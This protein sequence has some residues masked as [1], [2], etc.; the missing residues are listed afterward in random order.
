VGCALG[1][2]GRAFLLGAL[3]GAALAVA[4]PGEVRTDLSIGL[5]GALFT[6][7][8]FSRYLLRLISGDGRRSMIGAAVH[9]F[10]GFGAAIPGVLVAMWL[11]E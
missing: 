6:N 2:S 5:C 8:L 9:A 7:C 1:Q 3:T 4:G 11:M 10:S